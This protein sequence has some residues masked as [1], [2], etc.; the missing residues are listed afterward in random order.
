MFFILVYDIETAIIAASVDDD[1]CGVFLRILIYDAFY[2]LFQS[3]FIV[4]VDV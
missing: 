1:M 2:R 3:I 4:I